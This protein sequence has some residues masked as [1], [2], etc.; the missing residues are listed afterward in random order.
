MFVYEP[1]GER[2][3]TE[4]RDADF[5]GRFET[6]ARYEKGEVRRKEIDAKGRGRPDRIEHLGRGA[7]ARRRPRR[8]PGR[9]HRPLEL[10]RPEGPSREAGAGPHGQ[11]KARHLGDALD[12]ETGK[13]PRVLSD[14]DGDGKVDSWRTNDA[15]GDTQQ[16]EE[17]KNADGKSD[18]IGVLRRRKAC[19]L[20]GR[21]RLR[22]QA[23]PQRD[24]WRRAAP[25]W[26][27]SG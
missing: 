10:L 4:E 21:H 19:A 3:A 22:R 14:T 5:D 2:I 23:R 8:G 12:V 20:R 13:E 6:R 9:P 1:G 24:A 26:P 17:D 15:Q 7:P 11:R 16:L 18:R 25:C 27:R